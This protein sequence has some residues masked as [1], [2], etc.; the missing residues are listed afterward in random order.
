MG[1]QC[2]GCKSVEAAR[3]RPFEAVTFLRYAFQVCKGQLVVEH[4]AEK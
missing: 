2:S 1:K 4:D 3:T